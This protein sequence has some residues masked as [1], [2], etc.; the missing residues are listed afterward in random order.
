LTVTHETQ[1]HEHAE[2]PAASRIW[3]V[4]QIVMCVI[5][6]ALLARY[7]WRIADYYWFAIRCPYEIEYGEG[8]LLQNAI[9][10]ARS[11]AVY[12][13]YHHY[14]Y[15][16]ATY[17]PLYPLIGALG[18][19]LTGISFAFGR[20]ISALAALGTAGL[21]WAMLRRAGIRPFGAA[22]GAVLFIA[23]P[24]VCWWGVVM[25]VDMT[26]VFLGVAGVYCVLRGG[27]WLIPAVAFMV[28]AVYTRQSQVAPVAAGVI[29]LWW[30]GQRRNAIAVG[31]SFAVMCIALFGA[32]ELISHGWF[33]QHVIV[34]NQNFWEMES[35]SYWWDYV[36]RGWPFPFVLGLGGAVIALGR[37]GVA[38]GDVDTR[39]SHGRRLFGLYFVF[40]MLVSLTAGK[41]GSTVNYFLE[42]LA[43]AC[44][45]TGV[46]YH[47]LSARVRF[48][49]GKLL[50]VGAWLVLMSAPTYLLS[51]D[52]PRLV[53]AYNRLAE[54]SGATWLAI[55]P[56]ADQYTPYRLSRRKTMLGG[57]EAVALIRS[58]KGD[59][60]SEDTG[61]LPIADR[62][63]LLD[64][65]KMTS[66]FH[67]G[68]WDQRPLV[69]DIKRRRFALILTRWDPV[70]GWSDRW[71]T[72]GNYRFSIGIGRA[73]MENYYLERQAGFLY[74]LRPLDGKH[75]SCAVEHRKLVAESGRNR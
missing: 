18:V 34:A 73:I 9:N 43:A 35:L 40:A 70:S 30:I 33:Y 24:I 69:T 19:K 61:L 25:R 20:A 21:I 4:A 16:V 54:T 2:A 72:Y 3:L 74:I 67:D 51:S 66:M 6:G 12:N 71:S 7:L 5:A 37:W 11:G 49:Y 29:Y 36:F 41:I 13:D 64:P 1:K 55:K 47:W 31:A 17:P 59:I 50:W 28:L 56:D 15:V 63:I 68:T 48:R 62:P 22:L 44:L 58:T 32:L 75:P 38:A 8:I 10:I 27:R 26:A 52:S 46:A 14:P 53:R 65:H 23:A 39:A 45:T 42:P 60:L 57:R